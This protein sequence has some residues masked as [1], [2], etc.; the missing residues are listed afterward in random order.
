ML[1]RLLSLIILMII[2][3]GS[4]QQL[5]A[6]DT[7]VVTLTF[8]SQPSGATVSI[9]DESIGKT[10][11]DYQIPV[12]L[13][14]I[15]FELSGFLP[16]KHEYVIHKDRIINVELTPNENFIVVGQMDDLR[17]VSQGNQLQFYSVEKG[18]YTIDLDNGATQLDEYPTGWLVDMSVRDQLS[19]PQGNGLSAREIAFQSPSGRYIYY[20]PPE[21]NDDMTF[22][23]YDTETGTEIDT[24]VQAP[25][26]TMDPFIY[27]PGIL[28]SEDESIALLN[29]RGAFSCDRFIFLE[30]QNTPDLQCIRLTSNDGD[31]TFNRFESFPTEDNL[32]LAIRQGDETWWLVDIVTSEARPL[33][34]EEVF[35]AQFSVDET[36]IIVAHSQGISLVD[37]NTLKEIQLLTNEISSEWGVYRVSILEN[38]NY[39]IVWASAGELFEEVYI[40]KMPDTD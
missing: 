34:F 3:V 5:N 35:D 12:G 8:T 11:L 24:D 27:Q 19:I 39:A 9:D 32:I 36:M 4:P 20:I 10:P 1:L 30:D 33:P 23:I 2:F 37:V 22:A 7:P 38:I 28:W 13:Y 40:Y 6:N 31:M 26:G 29:G 25:Q 16:Q 17:A 18:L 15:E 21:E 14:S